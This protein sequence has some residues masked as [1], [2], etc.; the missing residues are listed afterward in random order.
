MSRKFSWLAGSGLALALLSFAAP[1]GAAGPADPFGPA[2]P[3]LDEAPSPAPTDGATVYTDNCAKCHGP[4]GKGDT[5]MGKKA[6]AAGKKWPDLTQSK[7]D[8]VKA[9]EVIENG[10]SG[11]TMKGYK[12]KLPAEALTNV[13]DFVMKLKAP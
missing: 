3:I 1:S 5:G 13:R 6:K 9:L 12:E 10:V 7:M 8:P 2:A 4:D 11:S